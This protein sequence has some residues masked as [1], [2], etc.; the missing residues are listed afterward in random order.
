M[1]NINDIVINIS[2]LTK[3]LSV[4]GFG[5]PLIL[6]SGLVEL[7]YG[8]Y[9]SLAELTDAGFKITDAEYKM[10]AMMFAQSPCPERI[11]IFRREESVSIEEALAELV[12]THNDWYA[13]LITERDKESLAESGNFAM[14]S[15]KIF[16]GCTAD[17][18]A[19]ENRN[20]NREAYLIHDQAD[21]YY[22]AAWVGL[23]LPQTVGTITW[24]WKTPTGVLPANFT[25]TELIEIRNK[26]GQTFSRQSGVAYSNEGI[27]TGAE[28]VDNM[29]GRDFVKARLEEALFNLQ[30]KN[31]K[32]SFTN[33]G[34]A[35]IEAAMREVFQQC[36]RSEIIGEVESEDD[37]KL[38]DEGVYMYKIKIPQ[39]SEIP[40]TDRAARK[41]P[42][43]EFSFTVAGAV[44]SMNVNG[45]IEV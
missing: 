30:I 6:G 21:Q 41:I 33:S 24:K 9:S 29:M 32:I 39:R 19:L 7:D 12:K 28:F 17:I 16:F 3:P 38:S 40:A 10:A 18:S 44:H 45:K 22:E 36:G 35:K 37:A 43:I 8:E 20:N 14:S 23:C 1:A 25:T 2:M 11:A 5:L 27:T 42:N 13:L 4:K 34:F 15:E 31:G 26:N